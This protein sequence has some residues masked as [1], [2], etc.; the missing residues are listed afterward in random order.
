MNNGFSVLSTITKEHKA[1]NFIEIIQQKLNRRVSSQ[2]VSLFFLKCV[3]IFKIQSSLNDS[4]NHSVLSTLC[5][6]RSPSTN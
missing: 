6:A 3:D 5:Q 2:R 1:F 4:F